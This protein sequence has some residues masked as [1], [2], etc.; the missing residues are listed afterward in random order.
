MR[1]LVLILLMST[2]CFGQQIDNR[3]CGAFSDKPFFNVMFMKNNGVKSMNGTISF[4]K[5][6][7]IIR[8]QNLVEVFEFDSAGRQ[9]SSINT[10]KSVTGIVDTSV[11]YFEY[12]DDTDL[13]TLK[14]KSDTYGFFSDNYVYDTLGRVIEKTYCRDDNAGK[15]KFN[16]ELKKQYV[17]VSEEYKYQQPSDL[18]VKRLHY[19]NYKRSFKEEYIKKDFNGYLKEISTKT[20]IGNRR[21]KTLFEYDFKGQVSKKI[22]QLNLDKS[23]KTTN[24][25]IYDEQ[26]NLIEHNFYKNGVHKTHRK[27]LYNGKTMLMESQLTKNMASKT[28]TITKYTYEFY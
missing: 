9:T 20:V 8:K 22:E 16:F 19:N 4:K 27:I 14:R 17:I 3:A 24:E 10:F 18:I 6:L 28:I 26:G 12:L 13:L 15:D 2:V 7:D 1:F 11:V 23:N 21:S 5:E 25:Y